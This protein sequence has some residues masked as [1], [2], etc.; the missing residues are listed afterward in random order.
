MASMVVA[1]DASARGLVFFGYPL[2]PPKQTDKLRVAHFEN[3]DCPMLFIQ[4]TRDPLCDLD[5]LKQKVID[6][7]PYLATLHTIEGGDHSFRVLKKLNR[8]ENSVRH[9]IASVTVNW[10]QTL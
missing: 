6:R 5:L 2:H 1:E 3:I 9:E 4:G 8:T 7:Y 10:M